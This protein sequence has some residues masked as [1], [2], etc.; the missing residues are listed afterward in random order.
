[1]MILACIIEDTD[2][3]T[4]RP[5]LRVVNNKSVHR[6]CN[7]RCFNNNMTLDTF[8]VKQYQL[9]LEIVEYVSFNIKKT[10]LTWALRT[11]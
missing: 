1:M 8:Y 3:T 6:N 11:F 2:S 5:A 4:V 9:E 7:K 10:L